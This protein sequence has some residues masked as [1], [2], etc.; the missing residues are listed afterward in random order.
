MVDV[1]RLYFF[2]KYLM[3]QTGYFTQSTYF[4]EF[5]AL[6]NTYYCHYLLTLIWVTFLPYLKEVNIVNTFWNPSSYLPKEWKW[7][8]D[9]V[10]L[11][12]K[13]RWSFL[14]ITSPWP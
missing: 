1:Q 13:S 12:S 5:L 9:V 11:S 2:K 4:S 7:I 10:Y 3:I 8:P 14:P 6:G